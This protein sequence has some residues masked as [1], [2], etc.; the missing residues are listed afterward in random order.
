MERRASERRAPVCNIIPFSYVDGPGNRTSIFFQGCG[1]RCAYCHNPE[2]IRMCIHCGVCVPECPAGALCLAEGKVV[3]NQSLCIGCDG[4]IQVCPHGSNPRIR[5]L[6]AD[7]LWAECTPQLPFIQGIT[8]SG[9]ECTRQHL[10]LPGLFDLAHEAGKTAFVDTNGETLFSQM[11]HLTRSMD[12]AMLDVKSALEKEHL[13]LTGRSCATVLENLRYLA[14]LGKLYE[15]RTVV[16][17]GL[18][19]ADTVDVASRILAGY[20]GVRY[21]L[22]RFRNWGVRGPM[23]GAESPSTE[24]MEELRSIAHANGVEQVEIV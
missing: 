7:E 10:F 24:I 1:F 11:P 3:W 13:T 2:S 20:P 19:S 23:E 4:C 6:T 18:R 16:A 8:V 9:G 5:C 12:M 21:K 14:D 17:P 15:I 22:I